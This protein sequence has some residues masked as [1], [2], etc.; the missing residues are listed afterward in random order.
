MPASRNAGVDAK[1]HSESEA[2]DGQAQ[3][4]TANRIAV[5]N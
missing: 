3:F 5:T 4:V 1:E 2:P